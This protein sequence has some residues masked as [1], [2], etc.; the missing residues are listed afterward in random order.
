M[1]PRVQKGSWCQCYKTYFS[2]IYTAI[3]VFPMILTGYADR[4]V[5]KFYN[6][7]HFVLM[8]SVRF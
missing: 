3:G 1:V 6:I 2:V 4:D 7:G 8:K 5:K